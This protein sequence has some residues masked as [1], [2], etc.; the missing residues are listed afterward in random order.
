[1]VDDQLDHRGRT[2]G[3]DDALLQGRA[4]V[5]A[6]TGADEIATARV[7]GKTG[8]LEVAAVIGVDGGRVD[9]YVGVEQSV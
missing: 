7:G 4:V 1:M 3:H 9:Q 2:V 5:A 6:Q 8:H